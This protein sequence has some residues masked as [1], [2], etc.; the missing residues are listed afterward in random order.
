ML[1]VPYHNFLKKEPLVNE[2]KKKM[3]QI[4]SYI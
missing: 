3:R 1:Y 2:G 4:I